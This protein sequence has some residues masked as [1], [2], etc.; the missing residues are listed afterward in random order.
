MLRPREVLGPRLTPIPIGNPYDK[1]Q[2]DRLRDGHGRLR[3][4]A[5]AP[6]AAAW[7]NREVVGPNREV[8]GHSVTIP[9]VLWAMYSA[10]A[11]LKLPKTH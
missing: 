9:G 7:C 11:H 5:R 6:Q 3:D 8:L 4:G 2:A 1:Y 10:V